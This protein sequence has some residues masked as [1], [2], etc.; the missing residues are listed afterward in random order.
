MVAL[1]WSA[2]NARGRFLDSM[3]RGCDSPCCF[4]ARRRSR[5]KTFATISRIHHWNEPGG[6][7]STRAIRCRQAPQHRHQPLVVQAGGGSFQN[8]GSFDFGA[9]RGRPF[10]HRQQ[11]F[12]RRQNPP[13]QPSYSVQGHLIYS[14]TPG[15]WLG[16]NGLYYTGARGTIDGNKGESLE[17]ARMGLPWRFRSTGT[18]R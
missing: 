10:L 5:L 8:L 17:N 12:S 3:I 7:S 2:K 9:R 14:I 4:T 16:L 15:V 13:S 6:H 1:N 18:T 11:R